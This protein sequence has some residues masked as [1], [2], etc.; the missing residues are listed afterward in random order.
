[1]SDPGKAVFLSYASQDA[2]VAKRI[3]DALR[4]AGLEVWFD[5]SELR[6]GDAWDALIRKRIK[7]CA[8]FVPLITPNT[9][10]RA[11]GYF[12]LEWKL[13]VDRSHLMADDAP[14]LFPV[15]L[16]EVSD[17]T[18]RVPDKFREV[19]WTRLRLD[20]TPAELAGRV[21]R[22]L[23]GAQPAEAGDRRPE[24]GSERQKRKHDQPR[25]FMPMLAGAVALAATIGAWF[26]LR[27][28]SPPA[29]VL[30]PPASPAA[31][32]SE[33]RQLAERARVM[34]LDKY[35]SS[36]DDFTAAEGLVKRALELDSNDGEIW[37]VSSL[38]NFAFNSRGFER[39]PVR[40]A[41]ARAHAERALKLA[42]ASI[43]AQ[44]ALARWQR[45]GEEPAIAEANF[46]KI[47]ARQPDHVG[48]LYNLGYLYDRLDRIDE[49]A[50]L[51]AR[52]AQNPAAAALAGFTEYLMYFRR[53]R[54]AE[55]DRAVRKSIAV[56]PSSNSQSGLAMLRLTWQGD[57]EAAAAA[58]AS[59]PAT[60]RREH[61]PIWVTALVHLCR[62][63]PA[64]AL[65]VL[66]R[67]TDEYIL[68]NWYTGPKAYWVGLAHAQA[69]REAAA[70]VAWEAGL[71]VVDQRLKSTPAD[72]LLRLARGELL[73]WLGREAEALQEV[74]TLE[75]LSSREQIWIFT[76]VRIHAA[77]GRADDALKLIEQQLQFTREHRNFGWPLTSALLRIDPRW[78]KIRGDPRFQALSAEPAKAPA[79]RDWP[80]DPDLQRAHAIIAGMDAS[81]ETVNLAEEIVNAVLKQRPADAEATVICAML[82]TYF[83]NRGYD[84]SEERY[85]LARRYAE[86]ALQL[87]PDDPEALA[88][89]AQFLAFRNT[90]LA[91]AET[92]I[93]RAMALVPE[94]PRFPRV[95]VYNILLDTRLPEALAQAKADC[96]R[97]PHDALTQ[98]DLALV[99][100]QVGD[101]A[102][103]EQAL[104]RTIALAPLGSAMVWKG[105]LAAWLHGDLA[106]FKTWLD[107]ISGNFRSGERTV[108]MRY[109]YAC[110]SG[111]AAYGLEAVRSFP[112]PWMNDFY[113]TGPRALLI[114]DLYALQGKADLAR[115]EYEKALAEIGRRAARNP[116][117][118]AMRR[119][120]VW[121]LLGLGRRDEA[122]VA[123]KRNLES[124]PRP[125]RPVYMVWWN[126]PLRAQLLAGDR[127]DALALIHEAAQAKVVRTQLQTA[128]RIDPRMAPFRGDPEIKALLARPEEAKP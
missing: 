97:F 62:R 120:E 80:K 1:M 8:L 45:D 110:L 32:L 124:L 21:A 126:H 19:Q 55:A 30:P 59:G 44:F 15:V 52:V 107:R 119:E 101:L 86:R 99:C 91:R 92:L 93:R 28:S 60:I 103:M 65:R 74:R 64:D 116:N 106:G 108:F 41:A 72:Y 58:V 122:R 69:G 4:A 50:A 89:M 84:Y 36:I 121:V 48:A 104:D 66:D 83:I 26:A 12:R 128:M 34:S 75:Q 54:F 123:A 88:A 118:A 46:L 40:N 49:A 42:P 73:A 11:E 17:A 71:A 25:R 79:A 85:V 56:E 31:P 27:P 37:A 77:L 43:E 14:F 57:A 63:Q 3:C 13:A 2:E 96:E 111:D 51:Y 87:A 35:D 29:S 105:W 18:A 16:G 115:E 23:S 113:F 10:A 5:Q 112:G 127:A 114:A 109:V 6:G 117:D 95:L 47:L 78:D 22:L 76:P 33:A 81:V 100:R 7:E 61:R 98:Y 70:R 9:N 82:H 39:T 125:F 53:A 102:L 68:D 24:A 38:I 20:E 94:E 90:D 67:L